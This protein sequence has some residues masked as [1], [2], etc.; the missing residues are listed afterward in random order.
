MVDANK[1]YSQQDPSDS[2]GPYNSRDFHIKRRLAQ[3]RTFQ[4]VQIIA[5]DTGAKTVDVQIMVNQLDG[6]NNSVAHGTI[7]GIPYAYYQFGKNA[8][9]ADPVIGDKG[10]MAICDR[11]ISGV[12]ASKAISNPNSL[13]K[14]D[15]ADGIYLGGLPGLNADPEQWVKFTD[16]GVEIADVN[17]NKVV[18]SNIGWTFTGNVIVGTLIIQNQIEGPG[19]GVVPGNLHMGGTVTGD[20]DVV[21]AGK[22]LK[23]HVHGGV[24]TGGGNTGPNT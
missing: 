13:R 17:N 8:V 6:Q 7:F 9:I 5:V 15:A 22:S 14:F 1:G 16:T 24:Q 12:V 19:G 2:A 3:I 20:S 11:D 4:L 23:A 10:T 21:A 18:S